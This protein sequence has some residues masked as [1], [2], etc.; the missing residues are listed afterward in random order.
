MNRLF[1]IGNGFDLAQGLPTSYNNFIDDFW[2]RLK[3]NYHQDYIKE[4]LF[5]NELNTDYLHYS[6]I[7]NFEDL[8]KNIKAYAS[9]YSDIT[10]VENEFR[11]IRNGNSFNPIFDFKNQFFKIINTNK[12][13]DNWVDIEDLYY[14]ELKFI[15]NS[16]PKIAEDDDNFT[17]RKKN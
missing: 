16:I 3:S 5:I 10:F 14:K 1:I 4:L 11:C 8:I 17:R 15:V 12:T 7:R 6:E 2:F 13:I 9:E